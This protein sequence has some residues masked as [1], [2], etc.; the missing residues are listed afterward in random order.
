MRLRRV[1]PE[2]AAGF[3]DPIPVGC[4]QIQPTTAEP[5]GVHAV[6]SG[7]NAVSRQKR[8][9]DKKRRARG[10]G[11]LFKRGKVWW[12]AVSF[13]GQQIREST[14]KTDRRMAQAH[15]NVKVAELGAA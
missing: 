4:D 13:R 11:S 10:K 2:L 9:G 8:Q 15:L 7:E 5:A 1:Q 3:P 12:I 14:G 6:R